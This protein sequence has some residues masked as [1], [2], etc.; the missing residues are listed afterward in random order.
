MRA[1]LLPDTAWATSK[2]PLRCSSTHTPHILLYFL[3]PCATH[4]PHSL[5]TPSG[6]ALN[7]GPQGTGTRVGK[8]YRVDSGRIC[9]ERSKEKSV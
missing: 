8:S 2:L 6:Y 1:A 9:S 3:L 7:P 4:P 5:S